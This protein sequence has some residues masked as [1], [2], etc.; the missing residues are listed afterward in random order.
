MMKKTNESVAAKIGFALGRTFNKLVSV[1]KWISRKVARA[2]VPLVFARVLSFAVALV[3]MAALLYISFWIAILAAAALVI[4]AVAQGFS[5]DVLED[6][7]PTGP[8]YEMG[9]QG[10]GQYQNGYRIDSGA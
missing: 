5:A 3:G 1:E 10:F 2:G 8:V 6:Y 9:P 4:S 7:E